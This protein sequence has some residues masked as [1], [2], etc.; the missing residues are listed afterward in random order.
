MSL[1]SDTKQNLGY[2]LSAYREIGNFCLDISDIPG[3]IERQKNHDWYDIEITIKPL[4]NK[5]PQNPFM[6]KKKDLLRKKDKFIRRKV[7]L[8]RKSS[9]EC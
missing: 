5:T 3:Y 6:T 9:N 2:T 8:L 1:T 7:K 4:K